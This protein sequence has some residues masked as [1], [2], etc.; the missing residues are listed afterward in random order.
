M[1]KPLSPFPS[2]SIFFVSQLEEEEKAICFPPPPPPPFPPSFHA[3]LPAAAAYSSGERFSPGPKG[4][5]KK[6]ESQRK[7]FASLAFFPSGRKH[8]INS[9]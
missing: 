1:R 6:G 2:F 8:E 9:V 4:T 5:E 7:S 3:P